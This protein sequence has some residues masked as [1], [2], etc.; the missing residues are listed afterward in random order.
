MPKLFPFAGEFFS[1]LA[2]VIWAFAVIMFKKSG[3]KVHPL[4]LN[5]FKNLLAFFLFL[6][7]ILLVEGKIFRPAATQD[8]LV[9]AASGILGIGIGDSLYFYSLNRLGAGL[10]AIVVCLYSPFIILLSVLW[11]NESMTLRQLAGIGLITSAIFIATFKRQ[12]PPGGKTDHYLTGIIF[13][14]L[15][16]AANAVSIVAAKK[17]LERSPV[18]WTAAVRLLGGIAALL[19]L[20]AV[21]PGRRRIIAV[22]GQNQR[23]PATIAGSLIGA[24]LAMMIWLAGMKFTTASV[25]SAL[26]QTNTVFIFLFAFLLLHEPL[27]PKKGIGFLLAM[28]GVYLVTF[29]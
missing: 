24:Y 1:L 4:G 8:Y 6:P 29:G 28:L 12:S 26:N 9:L 10:S 21:M 20:L 13:G 16:N 17:V 27:T 2:A 7:T 18:L 22:F 11:L 3:E 25:A 5:L 23:W 15:A 19:I 14:V